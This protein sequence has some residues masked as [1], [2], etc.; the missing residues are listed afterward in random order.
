MVTDTTEK[1]LETLIVSHMSGVDGLTLV[2]QGVVA[3]A[4]LPI[5]NGWLAG[6]PKDYDPFMVNQI[7]RSSYRSL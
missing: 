3:D 2:A 5:G 7:P 1:G 6:N 4:P